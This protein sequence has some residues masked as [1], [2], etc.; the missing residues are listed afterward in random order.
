MV[1]CD[2][3]G[4]GFTLI[5]LRRIKTIFFPFSTLRACCGVVKGCGHSLATAGQSDLTIRLIDD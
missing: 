2:V 1:Q 5:H 4:L 3:E